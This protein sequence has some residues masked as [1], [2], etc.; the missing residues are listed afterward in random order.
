[1]FL[2]LKNKRCI[3]TEENR[4]SLKLYGQY[5][6]KINVKSIAESMNINDL[7]ISKLYGIY[8]S[9]DDINIHTL[10]DSFVIKTNH[11]CGD[12]KII[13]N[14]EMFEKTKENYKTFFNS[15]VNK[16][17]RDGKEPHYK[18]IQPKIFIEEYLG[19]IHT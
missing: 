10:P 1:M 7:H 6:D 2:Y 12:A 5:T 4:T 19:K 9:Y 14:K 17:Y 8:D 15:I 18:Y 13:L 3:D 11:W 16:V